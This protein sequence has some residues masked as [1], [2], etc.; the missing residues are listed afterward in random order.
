MFQLLA[1]GLAAMLITLFLGPKFIEFLKHNEFRQEVREEGPQA[2]RESKQG[3]P[4][5]GGLLILAGSIV[6]FLILGRWTVGGFVVI[7]TIVGCAAIGF[8]DDMAKIRKKRSLG[9]RARGKLGLQLG[10][11]VT[12][13]LIAVRYGGV[14]ETINIPMSDYAFNVGIAYYFIIFL[15]VAG[16]SNAVNFTDGLDGLAAGAV[17]VTMLTYTGIAFLTG[18]TELG[19]ISAC[20]V[21][22]C[23]GFLWFN[24]FPAEVFMGDTGSMALGGA[25]AAMAVM[26]KTEILLLVIGG[27]FV[28]ETVSVIIQ[29]LSYRVFGKRVFLMTPIHHHFEL[30]DWSETKIIMRFWIVGSIFAATGFTL[31]YLS[32]GR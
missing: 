13:G 14:G 29:V 23:V 9:L 18:Q 25:I 30:M 6:P 8:A 22:A 10:L 31:F 21:G 20:V 7:L 1:A 4:T 32:T 3:I 11:S 16:T 2:H 26:T 24:S 28:A 27:I 19:I 15:V 17:A 12:V 5:L